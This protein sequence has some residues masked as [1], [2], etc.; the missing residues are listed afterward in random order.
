[1]SL[2]IKMPKESLVSDAVGMAQMA[3]YKRAGDVHKEM[4]ENFEVYHARIVEA[5]DKETNKSMQK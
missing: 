5:V 3:G 4:V 1:M 2:K